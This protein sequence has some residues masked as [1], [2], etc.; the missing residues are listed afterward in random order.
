MAEN[1]KKAKGSKRVKIIS[2]IR[3]F[4]NDLFKWEG[5]F[6]DLVDEYEDCVRGQD[7]SKR[8]TLLGAMRNA[9][10][11]EVNLSHNFYHVPAEALKSPDSVKYIALYRSKNLFYDKEPGV[12]HYGKVE[13]FEK[14]KRCDIKELRPSFASDSY[15]YRF[16]VACWNELTTPIKAKDVAPRSCYM[17]NSYIL[18]NCRYVYELYLENNDEFKLSIALN[19]IINSLYDGFCIKDCKVYIRFLRITVLTPKGKFSYRVSEYKRHPRETFI[20][21][22]NRLF[23]S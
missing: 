7:L 22:R 5:I 13:C 15:Y 23:N 16:N 11:Y 18:H 9:E 12:I 14:L 20:K 10:Q 19:D 2:I 21:I 4:F 6:F 8:D 3:K 1:E 17:T